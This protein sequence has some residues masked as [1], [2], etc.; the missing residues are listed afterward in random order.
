MH[1]VTTRGQVQWR[2]LGCI[3]PKKDNMRAHSDF[4][5][6]GVTTWNFDIRML[7]VT[8]VCHIFH[9]FGKIK[10]Q[11]V[12][13]LWRTYVTFWCF[14]SIFW[15]TASC[16]FFIF[17]FRNFIFFLLSEKTL[18]FLC[19]LNNP[20]KLRGTFY[21]ILTWKLISHNASGNLWHTYVTF[22]RLW[23]TYVTFHVVTP[24]CHFPLLITGVLHL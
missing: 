12:V 17:T 21:S 5:W 15:S 13:H 19:T 11:K 22:F 3:V 8:H 24:V 6:S 4:L 2:S 18:N 14:W 10:C 20:F 1:N 23:R 7:H 16:L 9:N